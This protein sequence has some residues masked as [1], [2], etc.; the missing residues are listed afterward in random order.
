MRSLWMSWQNLM[1][2]IQSLL[3]T[4]S[5]RVHARLGTLGTVEADRG[6][7][8]RRSGFTCGLQEEAEYMNN[9]DIAAIALAGVVTIIFYAAC[10]AVLIGLMEVMMV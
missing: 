1:A 10:A 7:A 6:F 5:K 8:S 2:C 9:K 4:P 3:E